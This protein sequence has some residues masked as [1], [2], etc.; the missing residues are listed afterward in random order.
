MANACSSAINKESK[1]QL[2]AISDSISIPQLQTSKASLYISS[3]GG[4]TWTATLQLPAETQ[5]SF[6]DT[7]SERMII[8]TDNNGLLLSDREFSNFRKISGI[9]PS[10][11][12]NAL[13]VDGTNIYVGLYE[14]GIYHTTTFGAIWTN[15][16]S[17]LNDK[18]VQAIIVDEGALMVGTDS[19]I[20]KHDAIT[21][22]W[23]S[24]FDERQVVSIKKVNNQLIAGSS[25]GLL[26]LNK[27]NDQWEWVNTDGAVHNLAVCKN[28]VYSLNISGDLI[29]SENDGKEWLK[30][31][32][33]PRKEAYLYD[34][35]AVNGTLIMTNYHGVFNSP[36][37]A[38]TWKLVYKQEEG[39]FFD[40]L[41][42]NGKIYGGLRR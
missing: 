40:L 12:I 42:V 41:E 11:K 16:N 10:E 22:T 21:N 20:S 17:N 32:Y 27:G 8:A 13:F 36:D 5:V 15:M 7:I 29:Y 30:S 28:I 33:G 9:L 24:V 6:M 19:G 25:H 31:E 38:K 1:T 23:T 4:A 18:R 26:K 35:I 2:G 37:Q 34:L 14:K 3:D 39:A